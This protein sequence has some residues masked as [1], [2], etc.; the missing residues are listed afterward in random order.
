MSLN[1]KPYRVAELFCGCGGLSHGFALA[2]RFSVEL[3]SDLSDVFCQTFEKNHLAE[4]SKPPVVLPGNIEKLARRE[5]P[6]K[7]R[8][9]GYLANGRLDVLL[10]GP[11]CE[12]FS[13]NKRSEE[14][15]PDS[16]KREY[17]GYKKHLNDPRNFLVRRFLKVVEDVMPKIVVIENVPQILTHDNGRVGAEVTARFRGLG[18]LVKRDLLFAP[19]YGIPQLRRSAWKFR[20]L[21]ITPHPRR[22][23]LPLCPS[24]R[25]RDTQLDSRLPIPGRPV[26][27][28]P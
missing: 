3:G 25:R 9:L 21:G 28:R 24:N 7:F 11:P 13:Q 20:W 26:R 22:T 12:G 14:V 8:D 2:G 6:L 10:G 16:G 27:R 23:L 18:Y 19:D 1:G 4:N 17:G 5:L 15:D